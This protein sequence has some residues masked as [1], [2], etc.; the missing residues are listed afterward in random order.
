MIEIID[1]SK[2]QIGGIWMRS[3][4]KELDWIMTQTILR[5]PLSTC[6]HYAL[7][8]DLH[9]QQATWWNL[10]YLIFGSVSPPPLSS[11]AQVQQRGH[12]CERGWECKRGHKC[13]D[14]RVHAWAWALMPKVFATPPPGSAKSLFKQ[15]VGFDYPH[16]LWFSPLLKLHSFL[17]KSIIP[18]PQPPPKIWG[19]K[20]KSNHQGDFSESPNRL[21]DKIPSF[22]YHTK[23][24]HHNFQK[25]RWCHQRLCNLTIWHLTRSI[26]F[27]WMVIFVTFPIFCIEWLDVD[28][29]FSNVN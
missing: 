7:T 18:R 14:A 26:F 8:H 4:E 11:R 16:Y 6:P 28:K 23:V 1:M 19:E 29:E 25:S 12:E 13:D 22:N 10:H 2:S 17:S 27:G 15:Q 20:A 3:I 5:L 24:L 9:P 21:H